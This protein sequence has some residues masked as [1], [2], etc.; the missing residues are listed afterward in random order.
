MAEP[1]NTEERVGPLIIEGQRH[2]L[3]VCSIPDEQGTWHNTLHFRRDGIHSALTHV[4]AGVS[5]HLPPG[6]ALS[7]AL[8]LPDA[9]RLELYRRSLRP[10]PPLA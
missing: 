5:W 2:E 8:A 4:V 9:E 3:W 10:R 6:D 7:R 1:R